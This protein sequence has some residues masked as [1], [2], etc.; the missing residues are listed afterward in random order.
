MTEDELFDLS[1]EELEQAAV[2]ARRA[3]STP[4]EVDESSEDDL[5]DDVDDDSEVDDTEDDSG[6]DINVAT[7]END[8]SDTDESDEVDD[9]PD[10]TSDAGEGQP[11]GEPELDTDDNESPEPETAQVEFEPLK[12]SGKSIPI[13]SLEELYTL[14]SGG[15]AVTQK[16]QEIAAHKKSISIMQQHGL[17]EADLSMLVEARSGNKDAL[18]S[19]VKQSGIDSIDVTDEVS[20]GYKPGM[21][22]PSDQQISLHDVQAE[23]QRD[24][25]YGSTRNIVNNL[26]DQASQDRL[27]QNPNM[28]RALHQDVKSGAYDLVS[29]HADKLKLMDGGARSDIEYYIQAAN[30]GPS[31]SGQQQQAPAPAQQQAPQATPK[32][33]VVSKK[34]RKSAGGN[35]QRV[36]VP[37]IQDVNDMSDE[38]LMAYREKIMA[39]R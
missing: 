15:A 38:D 21:H 27:V 23:I 29:A 6:D 36:E 4:D 35:N 28:I 20:E 17:T 10:E 32:K 22:I 34:N 7:N 39:S 11:D 37:S 30:E 13:N 19:L 24:P 8:E 3:K 2:E 12:V 1:D 31:D 33:R 18:A 25:E 14:A 26:M 5:V 9:A 16:F